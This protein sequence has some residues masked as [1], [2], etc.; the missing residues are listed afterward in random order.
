ML[1]CT[2]GDLLFDV[3]VRLGE[4]LQWGADTSSQ[5]RSGAGGQAANVAAWAVEL[6]AEARFVGKR[7]SDHAGRLVSEELLARGV[8]VVGPESE[9]RNGVV[10]SLVGPDGDRTMATDRGVAPDL[11]AE[12]LDPRWFEC[13]RLH[14]AGYS[15]LRSPIDG[16]AVRAASLARAAG[17]EVSVDLSSWSAIRTY[18]A[19]RFRRAASGSWG[20]CR[21]QNCR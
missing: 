14:L 3:I 8:D 5:T 18:G 1:V 21:D 10:V 19:A 20:R 16:A 2:L 15:L 11:R 13:D 4:P 9:G 6:G 7:A 12:E 17:A